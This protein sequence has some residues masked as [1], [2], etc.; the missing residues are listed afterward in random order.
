VVD[1]AE[2]VALALA[3]ADLVE[4]S[5]ASRSIL[6]ARSATTRVM[7]S[8]TLRQATRSS[9]A[10]TDRVAWQTSH[11]AV[12]SNAAVNREPGRAQGTAA[13]TTPCSRHDTRDVVACR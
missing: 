9:I 3:V 5:P 10:T 2:Q 1:R 13:T 6:P 4:R 11:A 8:A 7:M 12:S